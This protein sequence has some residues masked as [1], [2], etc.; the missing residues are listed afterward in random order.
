[1]MSDAITVQ[2]LDR[3]KRL[4][5]LFHGVGD[6]ANGMAALGRYFAD[7]LADACVVS[8][9][10]PESTEWGA[11]R[12]WFSVQGVTEENRQARVDAAMS[13][14][15]STVRDWQTKSGVDAAHTALVGF[16][17]GTI[18]SL[19]ALR[20]DSAIAGTVIAFSGRFA[21]LPESALTPAVVHFIHGEQDSVILPA[22]ARA[23]AERLQALGSAH[24]LDMIAGVGHSIDGLMLQQ[25]LRYLA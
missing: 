11:G 21:S 7:A 17:Q 8:V 24:S 22:R 15:L 4:V 25:A 18:M 23:A 14:F 20:A 12:Q 13:G 3:A 16:S 6:S 2:Q 19:E 1:M 9:N 10:G 5:L